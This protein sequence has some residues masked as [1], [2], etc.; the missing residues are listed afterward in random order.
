MQAAEAGKTQETKSEIPVSTGKVEFWNDKFSGT[1][2]VDLDRLAQS[3]AT[4]SGIDIEFIS[5]TDVASMRTA[6]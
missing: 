1:E 3:A 4:A 5:Y 2:Q 6:V